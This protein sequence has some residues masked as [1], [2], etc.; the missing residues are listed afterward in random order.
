MTGSLDFPDVPLSREERERIEH[1]ITQAEAD[2]SGE[3]VVLVAARTGLYRSIALTL[4]LLVGLAVPWPLI[5]LTPLSASTIAWIQ[6]A[7]VLLVLVLSL[8]ERLR[9]LLV[10]GRVKQA[11]AREAAQREFLMRGLTRTS[12][13]TGV[14]IF[15]ALA[16]HHA[17]IVSDLGIRERLTDDTW[18]GII[19]DLVGR[20]GNQQLAEGLVEA[21]TRVGAVLAVTFPAGPNPDELP[22]RVIIVD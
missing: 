4:A 22:N 8:S 7:C 12:G 20:A 21:V 9:L 10:P 11:R 16:E 15:V 5:L 13:R 3:I 1:A 19:A 6:A 18:R 14:L 2:T 17:E